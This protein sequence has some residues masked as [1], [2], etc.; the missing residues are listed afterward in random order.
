MVSFS[1]GTK[2]ILPGTVWTTG[3]GFS[4]NGLFLSD[5]VD[6]GRRRSSNERECIVIFSDVEILRFIQC[7]R[8]Q[9]NSIQ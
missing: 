7:T 9:C 8:I 2:G 4:M 1:R 5:M 6:W 3:F